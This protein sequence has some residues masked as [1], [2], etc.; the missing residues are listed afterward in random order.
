MERNRSQRWLMAAVLTFFV[1]VKILLAHQITFFSDSISCFSRP[2]SFYFDTHL[3]C[4]FFS[5][6]YDN[7]DPRIF[8]YL[9]AC[10]WTLFGKSMW[11]THL[12]FLPAMLGAVWQAMRLAS[13]TIG[14]QPRPFWQL[15]IGMAL[16]LADPTFLTQLLLPGTDVWL[17]FFALWSFNGMAE[18]NS[19]SMSVAWLLLC[20]VSRRGMIVAAVLMIVFAVQLWLHRK[21]E[22]INIF[23]K[24][25]PAIPGVCVVLTYLL[26]RYTHQGWIF[27]SPGNE[28][29]DS[30]QWA[31][32][33]A[34]LKNL[35]VY[36]WRNL[37]FGRVFIWIFIL[38]TVWRKGWHSLFC[39]DN[40]LLLLAYTLLQIAFMCVTLPLQNSFG[41]RYFVMQYLLLTAIAL[42]MLFHNYSLRQVRIA[43]P[44]LIILLLS[45]N[46]WVYP[47]RIA[48]NWDSTL[49]HLSFYPARNECLEYL[50][51]H[52][53]PLG[54]TASGFSIYGPQCLIFANNDHHSI[55]QQIKA[56]TR[57]YIYSNICNE[58][59]SMQM[60]LNKLPVVRTFN[61]DEI[62]IKLIRL[63]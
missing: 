63:R 27:S 10:L 13:Q 22:S 34:M 42:N 9:L 14:Y 31:E 61:K 51:Q 44:T 52:H 54:Q 40:Q 4:L 60:F 11:V 45:G 33:S 24:L 15:A 43:G 46:L 48:Q 6:N 56:D 62:F 19:K 29:A 3:Q 35:A 5:G 23:R 21:Q 16:L 12:F 1:I 50:H 37:D 20:M 49:R 58:S 39:K 25:W 26:L 41:C 8:Q 32:P 53:I 7:G 38:L 55:Q 59:D 18:R 30:G 36:G 47:E 28:W 57:Y 2:A 17:L